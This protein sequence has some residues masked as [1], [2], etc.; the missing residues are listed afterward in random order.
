MVHT[1]A[2]LGATGKTGREIIKQLL[3]KDSDVHVKI[4]VRSQKKLFGL[5]PNL[6]SDPRVKV[7]EGPLSDPEL[8]PGACQARRLEL[9]QSAR[10]TTFLAF[11]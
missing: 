4:Y 3:A 8:W 7:F 2:V 1:I 5:L 6:F 9:V 11:A 10:T